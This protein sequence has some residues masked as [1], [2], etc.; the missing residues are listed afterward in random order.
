MQTKAG[1]IVAAIL[2]VL[3]VVAGLIFGFG[4]PARHGPKYTGQMQN[5]VLTKGRADPPAETWRD[6]DGTSVSLKDFRGKVVLLNFWASWCA[7]C[8]RELPSI[9]ALQAKLGG[10][11]FQVVALNL[12][13]NGAKA[14]LPM[15]ERL[16]LDRL[17]LQLDPESKVAVDLGVSVMPTTI[18]YDATGRELGRLKGA[19]EWNS[20]EALE[21]VSYFI[22]NPDFLNQ[23]RVK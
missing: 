5:F 14:A 16:K 18:V 8:L 20:P 17:K 4:D 21:L 2:I 3:I 1:I 7:P 11:K 23:W 6:A 10:D 9:N 15:I 22:D 12:D 19:A 13:R